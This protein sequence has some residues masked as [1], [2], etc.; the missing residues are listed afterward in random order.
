MGVL[1]TSNNTS[2]IEAREI[3]TTNSLILSAQG[4][5]DQLTLLAGGNVGVGASTPLR[6]LHVAGGTGFAVNAS[7]S[8]YYG[9]YIPAVGEGADPRIDIGDWHNAGSSIKWDSSARSLNLDTQYSTGAGTF[10]ITGNDGASTFLTVNSSG[11]VGIG[12]TNPTAAKLVIRED[13]GYALRTENASG[14]TLRM[15]GDTGNLEVSGSVKIGD[16]STT[17]SS[18]NVGT[19]RYRTSGNNSYVDMCMQTGASTYAWINIVQNNW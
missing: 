11:N 14:W 1:G 19:Q 2:E 9:V 13:T 17:A 18:S 15:K 8:Q 12:N 16:D 4:S 10:N 5:T 3:G 6:R 7:T